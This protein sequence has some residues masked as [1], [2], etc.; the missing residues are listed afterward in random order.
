MIVIA[1]GWK[2]C[3]RCR[4]LKP[5]G[6]FNARSYGPDGWPRL[7]VSACKVCKRQ[8]QRQL[9]GAKPRK[10]L[11]PEQR[12]LNRRATAKRQ[13]ERIKSDPELLT[14]YRVKKRIEARARRDRKRG[15]PARQ[16]PRRVQ[17][18]EASDAYRAPSK[19]DAVPVGPLRAYLLALFHDWT[20]EEINTRLRHAVDDRALRRI[21]RER[22]HVSIEIVD[23]LLTHGLGRPDLLDVLYPMEE[24]R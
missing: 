7:R 10:K 15:G 3:S 17:E 16:Y 19:R 24:A 6:Q 8:R 12:T 9:T 18:L 23:R 21:L 1:T 22:D 13:R 2:R 11:T 4:V 5:N 20:S 14:A